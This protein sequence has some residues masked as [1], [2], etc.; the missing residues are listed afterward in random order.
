MNESIPEILK[1]KYR[2]HSWEVDQKGRGRPDILFSFLLDSAWAH[3]NNSDFSYEALREEGQLWVLSRFLAVFNALPKWDDEITI[4]TWS[5]GTDRLFGLRD[6]ALYDDS[7]KKLASA[8][9]AWL[10]I[11]R[12]TSRIQRIDQLN[13]SFPLLA[14]RHEIETRLEKIEERETNKTSFKHAVTYSDIDVNKHVNSAKY[15]T[16]MLDSQTV[17]LLNEKE[18]K[19]FEINFLAEAQSGDE[20]FVSSAGGDGMVYSKVM[21]QKDGVELCR[22]KV[23]WS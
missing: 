22:A 8:T 18:L 2:L 21:R 5:K 16:W 15:L 14:D 17:E 6:F 7:G 1:R 9:S 19:S 11:D 20:V 12:K 13:S 23:K 4:E 10:V 3:A